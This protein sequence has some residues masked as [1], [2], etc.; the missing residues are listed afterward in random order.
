MMKKDVRNMMIQ[1]MSLARQKM[2]MTE[3][4]SMN[5]RKKVLQRRPQRG[6]LTIVTALTITAT[7]YPIN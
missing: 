2:M 6:C 7:L 4:S 3:K 1:A 5:L